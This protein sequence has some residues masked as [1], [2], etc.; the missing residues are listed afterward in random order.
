MRKRGR[1]PDIADLPKLG[2]PQLQ[3]VHRELFGVEHPIA[4]CQHLRRKIAWHLQ[5]ATEGGPSPGSHALARLLLDSV[6]LQK[7]VKHRNALLR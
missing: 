5:A 7:L 3:A 4:N 6:L 2:A 1:L